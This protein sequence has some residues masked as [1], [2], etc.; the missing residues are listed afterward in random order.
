VTSPTDAIEFCAA[1]AAGA[2]A[3]SAPAASVNA[4]TAPIVRVRM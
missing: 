1:L 2:D 3:T 4:L